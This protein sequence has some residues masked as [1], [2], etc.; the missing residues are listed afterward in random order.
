MMQNTLY[1]F[2][3]SIL[4]FVFSY[5]KIYTSIH[6]AISVHTHTTQRCNMCTHLNFEKKKLSTRKKYIKY[7]LHHLKFL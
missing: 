5:T 6:A 3:C 2:N 1:E 4:N 7:A